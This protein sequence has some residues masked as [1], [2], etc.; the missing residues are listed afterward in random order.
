M[1]ALDTRFR[2]TN[3]VAATLASDNYEARQLTGRWAAATLGGKKAT[4]AMLDLFPDNIVSID[5]R[6]DHGFLNGMGVKTK[7]PQVNGREDKTGKYSG[8]ECEIVCNGATNGAADGGRAAMENCLSINPKI[9]L[10]FSANETSGVGAV[11]ALKAAGIKDALVVSIN[12]SR[13]GVKAVASGD[14]ARSR[15]NIRA[16]WF[17]SASR[18]R[19]ITSATTSSRSTRRVSTSSIPASRWLPTIRSAISRASTPRR[20]RSSAGDGNANPF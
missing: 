8:G 20:A 14:L 4:I 15:S 11:Q 9:N 17:A 19:S 10:V 1:L 6:R 7:D 13:R 2:P 3:L 16:R 5:W 18:P 12:G